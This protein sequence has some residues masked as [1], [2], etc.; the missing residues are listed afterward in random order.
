MEVDTDRPGVQLYAG[1]FLK[2]RSLEGR[3]EVPEK[4]AD[5]ALR[6]QYFPNAANEPALHLPS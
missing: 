5:S 1:N 2:E 6:T 3:R 4:D